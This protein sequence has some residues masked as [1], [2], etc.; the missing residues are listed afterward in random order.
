MCEANTVESVKTSAESIFSLAGEMFD[1][2]KRFKVVVTGNSMYPL[3]RHGMDSVELKR[4]SYENIKI[5]DIVLAKSNAGAYVLHR[6]L[7]KSDCEFSMM[8][9]G[10][11]YYDGPYSND[12]L[13]AKVTAVYRKSKRIEADNKLY[14]IYTHVWMFLRPVR[15][16]MLGA[17]SKLRALYHR[18]TTNA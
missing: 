16:P 12:C 17:I 11:N 6:V 13:M 1:Y 9:D 10:Q 2:G 15:K 4:E 8:G 14:G 18:I 3:L 7:K 5:G